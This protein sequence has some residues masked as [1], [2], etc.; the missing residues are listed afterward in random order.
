MYKYK[1]EQGFA[2]LEKKVF[3]FA[4]MYLYLKH[5]DGK[6]GGVMVSGSVTLCRI[7]SYSSHHHSMLA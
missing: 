6:D 3:D 1:Q 2:G 7:C 5:R 4:C